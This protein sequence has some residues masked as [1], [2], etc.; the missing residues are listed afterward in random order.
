MANLY[1]GYNSASDNNATYNTK[2][3]NKDN[4]V[5]YSK[6]E[7]AAVKANSVLEDMIRIRLENKNDI[8]IT[9]CVPTLEEMFTDDLAYEFYKNLADSDEEKDILNTAFYTETPDQNYGYSSTDN[10]FN[11]KYTGG[12]ETR[13]IGILDGD[14]IS[15]DIN[16]IS[17]CSAPFVNKLGQQY[18]NFI[19][20][21]QQTGLLSKEGSKISLRCIGI[22]AREIPHYDVAAVKPN[23]IKKVKIKDLKNL[24]D[25]GHYQKYE[26][27]GSKVTPRSDNEEVEAL[28]IDGE[29]FEIRKV[30]NN[31]KEYFKDTSLLNASEYKFCEIVTQ[32]DSEQNTVLDGLKAR[33]TMT[34]MI[35]SADEIVLKLDANAIKSSRTSS[36]NKTTYS[37]WWNG[38][39]AISALIDQW[40]GAI[41]NNAPLTR[42]SFA[43]M[44]TDGHGRFVGEIFVK[45]DGHWINLNK[46]ILAN[47]EQTIGNPT[48]GES[49]EMNNVYGSTSESFKL[50][51]YDKENQKYVD[52]L[53]E[54]SK[55]SY[56]G[57]LKFHQEV[58]GIDFEKY[59]NCTMMLGDTL[60]LIPPI[61][62]RNISQVDYERANLLRGK[63]TMV[64]SV[65]SREQYLEIDLYFYDY[66]GINGIAKNVTLPNGK[67]MTYYMNGLRALIA[68]F[69]VAPYL[70]IENKYINDV[71][72]IE[73]VSLANLAIST[74]EGYPR[75]LKATLVL[76]EFNYRIFMPDIPIDIP[77]DI[78]EMTTMN[79]IFAKCF[80]WEIFRY[81]YQRQIAN[82]SKLSQC[83]FNSREYNDIFY[84]SKNALK[85]VNFCEYS[86]TFSLYIPDEN[87]LKA[88]L[89]LKKDSDYYGQLPQEIVL[90]EASKEFFQNVS[91]AR[92]HMK[93]TSDKSK[94]LKNNCKIQKGIDHQDKSELRNIF[95]NSVTHL[96]D[97]D[98][99]SHKDALETLNTMLTPII[100][101]INTTGAFTY[102]ETNEIIYPQ[103]STI[104]WI[105][106]F[107]LRTGGMTSQDLVN[108]KETI[109]DIYGLNSITGILQDYNVDVIV[110]AT[111]DKKTKKINKVTSVTS[112]TGK[113]KNKLNNFIE[114][115]HEKVAYYLGDEV[116]EDNDR[117]NA[118]AE[119]YNWRNPAAMD[120]I[121]YIEDIKVQGL[122][123]NM[124]NAFTEMSLKIMEGSAPQYMGAG[125]LTVEMRIVTDDS[126]IVALLNALPA[127][128]MNI[129]KTYR[130]ILNCWPLRIRQSYLNMAGIYEVLID[131]VTIETVEGYPGLHSIVMRMT[132]VDRTMRNREKLQQLD[133]KQE[134][135]TKAEASIG[136]YEDIESSLSRVELYPDLDLPT[137]NELSQI[138]YNFLCYSNKNVVYPDPDFYM[139]Y[140]YEY[141]AKIIK[142]I[143]KD[144]FLEQLGILQ[145]EEI[146]EEKRKDYKGTMVY[147]DHLGMEMTTQLTSTGV[148][149]PEGSF[150]S[151][152]AAA[153][154]DVLNDIAGMPELDL[155]RKIEGVG[156]K[157]NYDPSLA[158]LENSLQLVALIDAS[159]GWKL[160]PGWKAPMADAYINEAVQNF[161]KSN[162]SVDSKKNSE[163]KNQFAALIFDK[164][165]EAINA[166]DNILKE[167]IDFGDLDQKG[168]AK[169]NGEQ[170]ACGDISDNIRDA[171][172]YIFDSK[173]GKKLLKILNP[174]GDTKTIKKIQWEV[175]DAD[176][177][178]KKFEEALVLNYIQAFLH[179]AG[180][181]IS[182]D[183]M[184][185][186]NSEYSDYCP[187]HWVTKD[188]K[189]K[190][191]PLA[192]SQNGTTLKSI[193]DIVKSG[194]NIGMYRISRES[195]SKILEKIKP[196]SKLD[197]K[198]NGSSKG[199]ENQTL[200]MYDSYKDGFL[201]P[202][203]NKLKKNSRE[204]KEYIKNIS[205][206]PKANAVAFLRI[207]LLILRKQII[208]GV[209]ISELDCIAD[210]WDEVKESFTMDASN[211]A[212][213][214]GFK[215]FLDTLWPGMDNI[216]ESFK[217]NYKIETNIIENPQETLRDLWSMGNPLTW[218]QKAIGTVIDSYSKERDENNAQLI[219]ENC[220]I[221]QEKAESLY[222]FLENAGDN[223]AKSL[224]ARWIYPFLEA[225]TL[226][227]KGPDINV[228][229][230]INNRKYDQLNS[231]TSTLTSSTTCSSNLMTKFIASLVGIITNIEQT[232]TVA[233]TT[234]D[235]Q[236]VM[237]S[238]LKEAYTKLSE[239]P[240]HYI[241]HSFYDMLVNDKRGRLLRAFPTYYIVFIDE[242]RTIGSWKLFDSFYNM[243]AISELTV[244]KTRKMPT[245]TCMFVM[246]NMFGSY[247][248][249]YDN[250]TREQYVDVYSYRDTFN[251]IFSPRE[252]VEKEDILARREQNTDTVV[253]SPGVRIHIRMGYGANASRLP[254]VFN[255]KV[256]EV[257]VGDVVT[258]VGQGD[259]C[260]LVNPLNTLGELDAVNLI[261][262]Q[263]WNTMFKDL[264]GSFARGGLSPR[265]LLVQL[266]TAE[267]GGFI[268]TMAREI[269]N[270]RLFHDN[271]FGI[272]HFGDK[273]FRDIFVEGEG[274]QNLYEVVDGTLLAGVN[275]LYE[276]SEDP[277]IAPTLNTTLQDKTFWDVLIMCA[278]SGN[279]YIGA[280]RDFGF[281]STV[282]LC[283]R[284]HYYAY[285]YMK[286]G[287]KYVEKRKP[288]QQYH[289]FDSYTDI[290]YN[291]IKA[292]EKNMKTNAT[293]IWEGTDLIWGSESKTCG[294][295]Y[296]DLNIYPEYQKAMTVDTGLVAAGNGGIDIPTL[297]HF[298]EEWNLNSNADKVNKSLAERITLNTLRESIQGMY[299]GEIC[300]IGNPVI[301]PYDRFSIND[302]YEDMNGQMEVEGVVYSM[303]FNTGFTTTVYPDLIVL[304]DDPHEMAR[305]QIL[306]N[307]VAA[308]VVT[309]GGYCGLIQAL[310]IKGTAMIAA[311]GAAA[312]AAAGSISFGSAFLTAI[313]GA[314]GAVSV[315]A[316]A[317]AAVIAGTVFV[318][319][320]NCKSYLTRWIR[321]IQALDVYPIFKN[322]R[323]LIAGM[324]GHRGS[325]YGYNYSTD[326]AEDSI[327][328]MIVKCCDI[329]EKSGI[330]E[331]L[332][333]PF[334][335]FEEVDRI[336]NDWANTMPELASNSQE[337]VDQ[338]EGLKQHAYGEV[339]TEYSNRNTVSR[340]NKKYRLKKFDTNKGTSPTYLRY[341][342]LGV[343][344]Y[345][346]I[347]NP[348]KPIKD[349]N[350]NSTGIK[351]SS[352]FS[353]KNILA[354]Y[355]IEDDDDVK[356][357]VAG[358]HKV[359]DKL[360][361]A[362]SRG[363]EYA[364]IPFESGGRVIRYQS[365]Q[366]PNATF[367]NYPILDMPM[368]QEDALFVLK[369]ILN[370][371]HMEG[372]NLVFKSGT[373]VNDIRTWK[374]TGFS[375]ELECKDIDAL[376]KAVST[377]KGKTYWVLDGQQCPIFNY[378][379]SGK[380][381]VITVYPEA[382][383][384]D[385][386]SN[387]GD[388]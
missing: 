340:I 221:S 244:T 367:A 342:I 16:R 305:Q 270:D 372:K 209:L 251:S 318:I 68:Q 31:G 201:D 208:D 323:P 241:L 250:T 361:I 335:D 2:K 240:R 242:G 255:G 281:R 89:Q 111:Y 333:K 44:G 193:N 230:Y 352:I 200:K 38:A 262:S 239:D 334:V 164:R 66:Y 65:S 101:K 55:D 195:K 145:S 348:D 328:G 384:G 153:Y 160:K 87:W 222:A 104:E 170:A 42:L 276:S 105:L 293:G 118:I 137:L 117:N 282:C 263:S 346:D 363:N 336:R 79:P 235:A 365:E 154:S 48:F 39:K 188:G 231:I 4:K 14:T 227:G 228:L 46:Y 119:K 324:N 359:V 27:S 206:Y 266:L 316:I 249:E 53:S 63:G 67:T 163:K 179:A 70:P 347:E 315:P 297:T 288:F 259:G 327:Q 377:I 264:R 131:N 280:V 15:L 107:S 7:D 303:N 234:S 243:S 24:K 43:P 25:K 301:K 376:K 253:L 236:R 247:A 357:A 380:T 283:K 181:C 207:M 317:V 112:S 210:N 133:S 161:E 62:I 233:S 274:V 370:D 238:I 158:E 110:T 218:G 304:Q 300:V 50:W 176:K 329:L 211:I 102:Q 184:K 84:T 223:Y 64:K 92:Q 277:A 196:S 169:E 1:E 155:N 93:V 287:D 149:I 191:I 284:N 254:V 82:G 189:T 256:A 8:D 13:K 47:T 212:E 294:P 166:I 138:G 199:K 175:G 379:I 134:T 194:T 310:A 76:R 177:L 322:Q 275:Q 382:E 320:K 237:N 98:G 341:R 350:G 168:D 28:L 257:D 162:L 217:E 123:W 142:R 319:T 354:L 19:H 144:V 290:I 132:S 172:K 86:D 229:N 278:Y 360:E 52:S 204:L 61:N 252:Y 120:F 385:F 156:V 388:K 224:C 151:E 308:A 378:Q 358:A 312:T 91:N 41:A 45:K 331:F 97:S 202:Y 267:H 295:I 40:N 34:N 272:Y 83:E 332:M 362:H 57:R 374:N 215:F 80:H 78:N 113:N 109:K 269:S 71:L 114:T 58:T 271:P 185:K 141:S 100:D 298:S 311:A 326:D 90:S 313:G 226:T 152:Q 116:I 291:S 369:F 49:P 81:F 180:C 72:G 18:S 245:D 128:T 51:T 37:Y 12:A 56:N 366:N 353:N 183:N 9:D 248:S 371:Q 187:R 6:E 129:S 35:N 20:Y 203:Y 225:G 33:D 108:V 124:S 121:S 115:I 23:Q 220:G 140:G 339:S 261:E 60:F 30:S 135:T 338:I 381:C 173:E 106:K 3:F 88:A 5:K 373:R 343:V 94:L 246:S 127:L 32:D 364:H 17:G 299:L 95:K 345:K 356:K 273:R 130:R 136:T 302:T 54:K 314:L 22:D 85:P 349:A 159:N 197:Y 285:A 125:D 147:K 74:V 75:L 296:L 157:S 375:F 279:G 260:E 306:S 69:K 268:K 73:A 337:P 99:G 77:N 178:S 383:P 167:P 219:A 11:L 10:V 198:A 192:D 286:K 174:L 122:A 258:I 351:P 36:K 355:P 232:D 213:G 190:N 330:G 309:L 321:N 143:I 186:S 139:V 29:Y 292:S 148:E 126:A 344:Q 165:R 103:K 325:V 386:G 387:G 216:K 289:H 205:S 368:I 265:N 307:F 26:I 171:V 150:M 182:G 21:C 96:R 214:E 59:R 146:P